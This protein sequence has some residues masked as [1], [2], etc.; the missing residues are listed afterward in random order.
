MKNSKKRMLALLLSAITAVSASGLAFA[1][2]EADTPENDKNYQEAI[3]FLNYLGI[4]TGDENGDMKPEETITRAEISAIILREM[5]ITAMS[6][7]KGI[8]ED[9]DDSHWAADVIQT[10]YDNGIINGY[11][12]GTFGPDEDVTYEQAVKMVMCAINYGSFVDVYGG[13]PMGYLTLANKHDVTEHVKGKVG[14][15]FTRRNAAKLVYNSLTTQ[16][17]VAVGTDKNA[18]VYEE[19]DGVTILSEKRDIYYAEGTITAAPGKSID[20]SMS[21]KEGQIGFENDI[22]DSEM[23]NP[24]LYVAEYVKLFYR[25]VAGD[26]SERVALYAC[27]LTT[28]TETVTLDAEIIE[29]IVTGYIS[30]EKPKIVYLEG[31]RE[32]DIELVNQPVIV[33]NDQPFTLANFASIDFE[34]ESITFDEFIKPEAGSVKAVDFGKDGDYDILFVESYEASVVKVATSLRLQLEYPLSIGDFIKL[35]TD[36]DDTLNVKV[37]KDGEEVKLNNLSAGDVISVRMNANFADSN[38]TGDKYITIEASSDYAEG[39]LTSYSYDDEDGYT[40][41]ID[42]ET[43]KMVDNED[44]YNDVIASMNTKG[45]FYLDK[46][47]RIAWVE[48]GV[49][50][51][52]SSGEK[53]G[54]LLNVYADDSGEDVSA[55]IYNSDAEMVVL[56]LASSVDYWAPDAKSSSSVSAVEIDSLINNTEEGNSYFLSC[57]ATDENERAAIRLCKYKTNSSGK[58]TRLYL[59]V[60]KDTVSAS[61]AAVKVDTQDHKDNNVKSGLF[62]GEYLMENSIPQLTVPLSFNDL[63]DSAVYG[64]R[65]TSHSEFDKK[66]DS[67]LGYNCFFA[68]ASNYEP[69]ITVR[70][71]KGSD[72]SYSIDEYSTADDNSVIVVSAVNPAV[73]AEGETVYIIKGYHN[74]ELVEYTT[75]KNVLV[76][77]V[78]PA[79]RL[80]KETYDTTTVWT[81]NSDVPLTDVLHAGDICGIKGSAS[82]VSI[83]M[84]M[85]DTTALAEHIENGGEPG[86]VPSTQFKCDQMFSASRD[87]V[88][89]GYVTGMRTSPIVMVDLAVDSSTTADDDG[90]ITDD[91]STLISVGI[92]DLNTAIKFINVSKSGKVTVE[93]GNS[94]AYEIEEDDYMFMRCF[95]NDAMREVYIIRF[96]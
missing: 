80:D 32:K 10:A 70:L 88:M 20:L 39:K 90:E 26:G 47:G 78:N 25:D 86:T 91:G 66:G 44:V 72:T 53:Y 7:Y 31:T 64:Y 75:E 93:K 33:Y 48:S 37:I 6:E 74:G 28:K 27:P 69:G 34:D 76:A 41:V 12:D 13:Y 73:D 16:Y 24:E 35:D 63:S 22:M 49:S 30:D 2:N 52:L 14:E 65:M 4:F 77:H 60:D 82:S 1:E 55:K 58:I 95:K 36:D 92:K 87:R 29:E 9:V 45:K 57:K 18:V 62:A 15:P 79:V 61:S 8:F 50:G 40:A 38:Y 19:K 96:N 43:Y 3:G 56:P 51:G 68:D 54:W 46:F 23:T 5:N 89:F 21:L 17:P 81:N 59:A 94:D 67:T 42:G 85:V 83:I 71:V 84:R 11:D